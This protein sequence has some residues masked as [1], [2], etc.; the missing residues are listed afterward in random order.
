MD[1]GRLLRYYK[2]FYPFEKV[3]S[4]IPVSENREISFTLANATYV[5]YNAFSTVAELAQRVERLCPARIDIG[6][7]YRDPP[8]KG[9]ANKALAK[10]L[11]FDVDLTDYARSCCA[12]KKTACETCFVVIKAGMKILDYALRRELGF[13]KVNFFF[14][15]GRGLHCWV[16]DE[17]A[18]LLGDTERK[19][20]SAYFAAVLAKQLYAKEYRDV[21]K[22][23]SADDGKALFEAL[24][25]RLDANVTGDTKHL[26]KAPFC[27]HPATEKIC[28]AL[29]VHDVDAL[30]LADIPALD[31]VLADACV[32]DRFLKNF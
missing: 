32:L 19:A 2:H 15:G 21:L 3:F 13:S 1:D 22:T 20:I 29:S 14:S 6:A 17:Q 8:K 11:V 30:R 31:D 23:Y 7:V 28:V 9:G 4:L 25:V 12:E 10:E 5:R 24:F 27:V 16:S 18:L 26:L